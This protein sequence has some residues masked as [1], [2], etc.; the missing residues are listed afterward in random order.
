MFTGLGCTVLAFGARRSMCIF[1]LYAV[2]NLRRLEGRRKVSGGMIPWKRSYVVR[3][4]DC[5]SLGL[6]LLLSLFCG[7]LCW[8]RRCLVN[9]YHLLTRYR[10][11]IEFETSQDDASTITRV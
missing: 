9:L 6:L 10:R 4:C 8:R 3:L 2:L 11:V 5:L 1:C 7:F